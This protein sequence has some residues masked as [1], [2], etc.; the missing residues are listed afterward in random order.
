[1]VA[2]T[3]SKTSA[4]PLGRCPEVCQSRWT[5]G[6]ALSILMDLVYFPDQK[7]QGTCYSNS[8]KHPR[9]DDTD[10]IISSDIL[11]SA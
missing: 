6:E 2:S 5:G 3:I 8:F 10:I 7:N 11:L 4:A 9:L 1:M